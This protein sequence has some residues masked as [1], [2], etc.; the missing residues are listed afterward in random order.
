MKSWGR[1]TPLRSGWSNCYF[2]GWAAIKAGAQCPGNGGAF[3]AK[4]AKFSAAE[5]E[6]AHGKASNVRTRAVQ[7]PRPSQTRKTAESSMAKS[8]P[9]TITALPIFAALQAVPSDGRS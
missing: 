3:P 2:E 6:A 7:A 9:S 8:V 5:S 4:V 1:W